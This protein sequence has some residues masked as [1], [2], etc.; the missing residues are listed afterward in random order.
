MLSSSQ[1]YLQALRQ[2]DLLRFLEWPHFLFRYY[3]IAESEQNADVLTDVLVCTWLNH[4]Y[5][6]A[7]LRQLA[8]LHKFFLIEEQLFCGSL[9]YFFTSLCSAALYCAAYRNCSI[10]YQCDVD[11]MNIE[12]ICNLMKQSCC[13]VKEEIDEAFLVQQKKFDLLV[14]QISDAEYKQLRQTIRPVLL[15]RHTVD[16]YLELWQKEPDDPKLD[17]LSAT[18]KSVVQRLASYLKDLM[19]FGPEQEKE[20]VG[21]VA[22]IKELGPAD[23]EQ[24]FLNLLCQRR[25]TASIE[26]ALQAGLC[27]L[28]HCVIGSDKQEERRTLTQ[29]ALW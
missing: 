5:Q 11:A 20:I 6:E 16:E 22:K 18:R 17:P 24:E 3:S 29:Q 13:H 21:Y 1:E 27:F 14:Q 28:K 9:E 4:G 2:T 10:R 7:D 8:L 19:V 15:L 26:T 23:S 12:D 25:T